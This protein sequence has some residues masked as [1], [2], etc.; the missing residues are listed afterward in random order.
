MKM[1]NYRA[2]LTVEKRGMFLKKERMRQSKIRLERKCQSE[3]QRERNWLQQVTPTEVSFIE[4]GSKFTI[5][6]KNY[7]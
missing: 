5:K 3:L 1:R 4:I 6:I 2:N 7:F